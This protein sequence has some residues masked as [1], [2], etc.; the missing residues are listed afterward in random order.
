MT[1]LYLLIFGS[2]LFF[3]TSAVWALLWAIDR[4]ELRDPRRAAWSILDADERGRL[5]DCFPG[6]QYPGERSP[7]AAPAALEG[8][9]DRRGRGGTR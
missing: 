2:W 9:P 8:A 3:V 4:K 6:E 5:N 7:G 1:G